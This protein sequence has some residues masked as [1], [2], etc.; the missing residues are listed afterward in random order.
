MSKDQKHFPFL[1]KKDT[2]E[3]NKNEKLKSSE[4]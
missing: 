4:E 3:K 2:K 1:R